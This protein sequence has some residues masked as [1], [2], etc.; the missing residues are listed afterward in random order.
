[1]AENSQD[2]EVSNTLKKKEDYS[3]DELV[4]NE[5]HRISQL[6]PEIDLHFNAAELHAL[7]Y[8]IDE[9][10]ALTPRK[11]EENIKAVRSLFYL[12]GRRAANDVQKLHE[13]LIDDNSRSGSI[14]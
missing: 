1:M 8:D 9:T 3:Q 4:V 5:V 14:S 7:L 10:Q 6:R 11:N 12:K 13:L 2:D